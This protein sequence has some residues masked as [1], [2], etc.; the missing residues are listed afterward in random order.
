MINLFEKN[1][2]TSL[3][4]NAAATIIPAVISKKMNEY[5]NPVMNENVERSFDRDRAC[6][7][8]HQSYEKEKIQVKPEKNNKDDGSKVNVNVNLNLTLNTADRKQQSIELV[9]FLD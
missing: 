5:S 9:R 8:I 1:N 3:L 4:L 6:R 2:I 7:Q